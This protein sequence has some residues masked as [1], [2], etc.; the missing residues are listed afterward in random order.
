MVI[1][2][3]N[4][5]E[6]SMTK[7]VIP[8]YQ[9]HLNAP[10]PI[11]IGHKDYKEFRSQLERIDELLIKGG[12]EKK[13]V[14]LCLEHKEKELKKLVKNSEDS[15]EPQLSARQTK[16]L[17]KVARRALRCSIARELTSDSYRD[18]SNRLAD[19]YLFQRFC[20]IDQ[21]AVIK[22]PSKSTLQRYE[23]LVGEDSVRKAIDHLNLQ[24]ST[25]LKE[26]EKHPL[27][28]KQSIDI[29]ESF[30]D[31][32]CIKA[33]IHF[34][35]DWVL[36][37]D[38]VLSLISAMIVIRNHGLK[39]RIV[40]PKTFIT[41]INNLCIQMGNSR[42]KKNAKK[43]RK[44][45]FRLMKE[46]VKT[47]QKHGER[48]REL[49]NLRREDTDLSE[50]EAAQIIKRLDNILDQLPQAIKQA[51]E[52]IIGERLVKN[53]DKIL[54]LH[55]DEIHVIVRGK[56]GAEVEYGNGLVLVEQK[57]GVI[58]DYDLIKDQPPAD[59]RLVLPSLKRIHKTF[60]TYPGS[61]GGDR[62]FDGGNVRKFL[63]GE[64]I[65]NG[66]CPKS[67]ELL[68]ER[69][70]EERFCRLQKRRAQTEARIGIF[71]NSFLGRPLRSKGF[72]NREL[73]V[74]WAILAHNLWCLARLP[75]C[76][77]EKDQSK[78]A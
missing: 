62:G 64:S 24:A 25:P 19:S 44:R 31:C 15:S 68:K 45:L 18:F 35:V 77:Q 60:G 43:E 57:E 4:G 37:R 7:S 2:F 69:Q 49:L 63:V 52:R 72:E 58:V 16:M 51:N 47:V 75:C 78:V 39:N 6:V 33:N 50:K 14:E 38:A 13:F 48:Y 42:R 54:S 67:P 26:T 28:L 66:I 53:E 20:L 32:T 11:V 74:G 5:K 56:A 10:L 71:K 22:P 17:G 73:S 34:P 76:E 55:E 12:V 3:V 29:E 23:K 41:R 8:F 21:L 40:E 9:P 36:L 30:I 27:D 59:P 46:L 70:K 61:I 1:K 65:Y